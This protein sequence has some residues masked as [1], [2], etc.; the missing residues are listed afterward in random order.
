MHR[1]NRMAAFALGTALFAYAPFAQGQ[2]CSAAGAQGITIGTVMAVPSGAARSYGVNLQ[3]GEAVI[4]DLAVLERSDSEAGDEEANHEAGATPLRVCR[5]SGSALA[6]SPADIFKQGGEAEWTPD[7][8]RTRLVA[9]EAG[10]YIISVAAADKERELLVRRRPGAS[11]AAPVTATSIGDT[12]SGRVSGEMPTIHSFTG[13]AGQWV[14]LRATSDNDTVLRLAA[15][16]GKG[17]Y[18]VIA[19]NDDTD[20][21][22]PAIRRRLPVSGTY[23]LQVSSLT[24]DANDYSLS[25]TRTAA[26]TP[27]APPAA[28]AIG[29]EASGR[30]ADQT[31]NDLYAIQVGAGRSYRVELTAN[32]DAVVAIGLPDP[33]EP[34]NSENASGAGFAALRSEDRNLTG[35]EV[36][37]FTARSDGPLLVMVS[38]FGIG[39]TNGV[40]TLKVVEVAD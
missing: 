16:D 27:P 31:D 4:I 38:S 33:T 10:R 28:L 25:L 32:Y 35:T 6:P 11:V 1:P 15:P 19:E 13:Q 39:D 23:Y 3:A 9:P 5:A 34:E 30:L 21:L 20:G 37:N 29:R 26:P 12:V 14:L 36:L 2:D 8:P 17:G 7:G 22:N 24:P 18:S 40:Y